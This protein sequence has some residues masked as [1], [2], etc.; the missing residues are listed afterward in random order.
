MAPKMLQTVLIQLCPQIAFPFAL[1][2][3]LRR[4]QLEH[5]QSTV[6]GISSDHVWYSVSDSLAP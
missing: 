5:V 1:T 2:R 4:R 3:M 6:R